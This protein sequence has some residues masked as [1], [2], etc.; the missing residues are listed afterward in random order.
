MKIFKIIASASIIISLIIIFYSCNDSGVKPAEEKQV[1]FIKSIGGSLSDRATTIFQTADGG[2]LVAGYTIS[3]GA[4]G[5]DGFALKLDNK[6]NTQWFKVFGGSANDQIN[7]GC[8]VSDGGYI[9][10]G[11]TVSFNSSSSDIYVVKLDMNGNLSW[12]KFYRITGN[13]Y[14]TSISQTADYGF[15][16]SGSADGFG[17]GASDALVMKINFTGDIVWINVYGDVFNDYGSSIKAADD[18][19]SIMAGYTYSGGAGNGDISLTALD[20]NGNVDWTKYYGGP[21]FEQ[22]YDVE[23]TSDNG[24]II[25]G[26]T[27]SFGLTS[28]D[29]Y[30][31]K[32]DANGFVYWS[33]TFGGANLD[34]AFSVKETSD[35]QY[36]SAGVTASFGSGQ[37]D[38]MVLKIFGDGNFNYA[39]VLGGTGNDGFT[40]IDIRSDTGFVVSG[41]TQSIGAGNNDIYIATM[42]ENGETCSGDSTITPSGGSPSTIVNSATIFMAPV[43]V[44]EAVNAG[45]MIN[46]VSPSV[47][48]VCSR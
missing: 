33:R 48:T 24:Y 13:E 20:P 4:G 15:L 32:T 26:T 17:A 31:I 35:G 23:Y 46:S 36:I 25:C 47:N 39:K 44:Y 2:S 16:I 10:V 7:G 11:E 8:Q 30:F 5:N 3:Y 9:F 22:P 1:N 27:Y 37:E 18:N 12:S 43:T 19:S 21:G 41:Y 29:E 45:T 14:G 42:N 38:A 40:G 34:Q 28:G 6:G